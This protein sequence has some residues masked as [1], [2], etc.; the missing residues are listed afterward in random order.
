MKPIGIFGGTF[1][2][3]HYGHLR[4]AIELQ[5]ILDLSEIRFVPCQT[6]VHKETVFAS[7]EHRLNMLKLAL[8][9]TPDFVVDPREVYRDTPSYMIE[10]LQS[11]KQEFPDTPLLLIMGSDAFSQLPTWHEWQSLIDYCHLLVVLRPGYRLELDTEMQNYYDKHKLMDASELEERQS[12]G[13]YVQTVTALDISAT[14]IR[15]QIGAKLSPKFLLPDRVLDYIVEQN[16]Y[17]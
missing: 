2:P 17:L 10:T 9:S 5:Q 13:I 1:D 15:T 7:A 4:T 6:P 12:G 14:M 11:L 16:L 3:I 8:Q